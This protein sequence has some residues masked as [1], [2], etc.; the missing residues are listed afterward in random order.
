MEEGRVTPPNKCEAT[1]RAVINVDNIDDLDVLSSETT[2]L[3]KEFNHARWCW[4]VVVSHDVL[5]L[6][7][8]FQT[9]TQ[10][11]GVTIF[12]RMIE[13]QIAKAIAGELVSEADPMT[14]Y[15]LQLM[16]Q[17][18]LSGQKSAQTTQHYTN[19]GVQ[20][21][22]STWQGGGLSGFG[23]ALGSVLGTQSTTTGSNTP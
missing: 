9:C 18:Q 8:P 14:V 10:Y 12:N 17:Q 4:N 6:V 20:A 3:F 15:G 22:P 11:N 19:V 23:Q 5:P 21:S 16:L 2:I 13:Q 1:R 7:A